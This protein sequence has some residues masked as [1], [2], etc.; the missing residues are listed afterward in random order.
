MQQKQR[1]ESRK[2]FG[3]SRRLK[4]YSYNRNNENRSSTYLNALLH[5]ATHVI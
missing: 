4:E 3:D 5:V 2:S 1:A